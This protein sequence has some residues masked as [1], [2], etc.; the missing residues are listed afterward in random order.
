MPRRATNSRPVAVVIGASAAGLFAAAALAEFAD[1]TIV[2]R[3][4][5][6]LGAEPRR[7]VPQARHA[8]LVWSGGVRAFNDLLPGVTDAVVAKGG[9]LIHVMGDMVSRSPN[10]LWFRR[11][12][13]RKS[14]V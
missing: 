5:L 1:V 6:P 10:E 8:H 4:V 12:T 14:V 13:D 9:R 11:F 7:G 2:E 3:D